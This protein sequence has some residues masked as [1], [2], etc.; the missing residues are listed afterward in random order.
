[1]KRFL[2]TTAAAIA[3]TVTIAL[4]ASGEAKTG[5]VQWVC[6]STVFVSAPEAARHGIVTANSRAGAVFFRQFGEVC[7]VE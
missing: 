7:R 4:P 1:M 2:K 3:A 5:D 6:D